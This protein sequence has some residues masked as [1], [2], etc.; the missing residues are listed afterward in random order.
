MHEGFYA[1]YK[2]NGIGKLSSVS[3]TNVCRR[4]RYVLLNTLEDELHARVPLLLKTELTSMLP[5]YML[6]A[7]GS[8]LTFGFQL[9]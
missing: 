1:G 9:Y 7:R 8:S 6:R 5:P 4:D 3:T 2:L